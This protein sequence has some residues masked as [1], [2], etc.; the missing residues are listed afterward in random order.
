[1][2]V[3]SMNPYSCFQNNSFVVLIV[4]FR[5]MYMYMYMYT[6]LYMFTKTTSNF[7]YDFFVPITIL[8]SGTPKQYATGVYQEVGHAR[9]Q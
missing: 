4:C 2:L 6:Y 8:N 9:L 5:Y 7:I 3:L 1:M